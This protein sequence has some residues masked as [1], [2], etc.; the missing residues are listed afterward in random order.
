MLKVGE[1][2]KGHP[3]KNMLALEPDRIVQALAEYA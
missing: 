3:E 1:A 2:I